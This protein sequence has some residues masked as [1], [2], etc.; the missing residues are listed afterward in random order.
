MAF[1]DEDLKRLKGFRLQGYHTWTA[2]EQNEIVD[3]VDAL[4]ARLEAANHLAEFWNHKYSCAQRR[5]PDP[6][7]CNCGAIEAFDA[8][9][10][11][12]GK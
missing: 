4:L 12:S 5:V 3:L 11:A 1:S 10:K 6:G 9:R 2:F 8:L 7:K